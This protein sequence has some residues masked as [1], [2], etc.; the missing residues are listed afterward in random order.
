MDCNC[1]NGATELD[2]LSLVP[3][4][5]A[6]NANYMLGLTQYTCGGKKMAVNDAAYPVI[7][8]LQASVIGTPQD[9]GNGAFCCEVQISGTVKFRACRDCEPSEVFVLKQ[10]CVPCS[11]ATAPTITIGKVVAQPEPI[12]YYRGCCAAQYPCTNKIAITTS[13]NVATA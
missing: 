11:S 8:N 13:I 7:A 1:K 2:F 6:E 10:F 9:I 3:G 5:T 12:A 4:G